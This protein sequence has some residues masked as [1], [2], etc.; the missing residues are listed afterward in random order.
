MSLLKIPLL[1]LLCLHRSGQSS[2]RR[3]GQCCGETKCCKIPIEIMKDKLIQGKLVILRPSTLDER[4]LIYD[5]FANSD[6]TASM[7]GEP[8]FPDSPPGSWEEFCEDHTPHFFDGEITEQ[9]RSF[10]IQVDDEP[11]GQ[12]YF[13]DIEEHKG[14]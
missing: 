12:I 4:R 13:N 7:A 8:I 2:Q 14:V 6:L 3:W 1:K 11:V 9:G 5:W 10:I